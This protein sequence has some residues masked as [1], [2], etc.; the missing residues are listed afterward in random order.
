[1]HK[2]DRVHLGVLDALKALST[3]AAPYNV[4]LWAGK[5]SIF[6][7]LLGLSYGSHWAPPGRY[8][9]VD[10]V[11]ASGLSGLILA[12]GSKRVAPKNNDRARRAARRCRAPSGRVG[13]SERWASTA[14]DGMRPVETPIIAR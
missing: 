6:A 12:P 9:N 10:V 14:P 2:W 1:M 4:I 8:K 5:K 3:A 13:L 7:L 11:F